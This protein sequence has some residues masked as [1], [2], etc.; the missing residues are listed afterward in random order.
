MV[1]IGGPEAFGNGAGRQWF[2]VQDVTEEN[3]AARIA[4]V[5]PQFVAVVRHWQRLSGVGYAGT[6][7]VG[8]SQGAIMALEALKAEN[9]LAGRVVA[10]S[11][12]FAQLP[13]QA[14]GDSV[15][16]LIHGEEDAVI[17]VQHAHAAA[18]ALRA[19]GADFTLDVEENVGHAIN[20]HDERRAGKAAL[21]CAAALL[22]RGIVRQARRADR[23]SLKI[24]GA[25]ERPD[26]ISFRPVVFVIPLGVV[27]AV[28][29]YLR[30]VGQ[31]AFHVDAAQ[32]LNAA[33]DHS[34]QNQQ[35]NPPVIS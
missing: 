28:R 2:S 12:R 35:D 33:D 7:L 5:M 4:D 3:R 32:F 34:H 14:F 11:G 16:H 26:V 9:R 10:F 31:I 15:V 17:A 21:L 23:L 30:L 1:S 6:A 18:E 20:R 27:V 8:F 22:G 19:G 24:Q 25:D 13:E 29:R